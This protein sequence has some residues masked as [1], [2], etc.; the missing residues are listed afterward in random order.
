MWHASEKS[1]FILTGNLKKLFLEGVYETLELFFS[2]RMS[3]EELS[4]ND[5][6]ITTNGSSHHDC[7]NRLSDLE[8][9][10]A[11]AQVTK[12]LTGPA[13]APK[14]LQWNES[15]VYA[16]F[17]SIQAAISFEI[18]SQ[19]DLDEYSHR[20]RKLVSAAERE[21]ID[22]GIEEVEGEES[23]YIDPLSDDH[24]EWDRVVESLADVILWD[25]DFL[26]EDIFLDSPPNRARKVKQSAGI[27]DDY[28][29][30]P[31]P[32]VNKL[33][34]EKAARFLRKAIK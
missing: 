11:V 28:F 30:T 33:R 16:V 7:Y 4:R 15:A 32:A 8:K 27:D 22:Y 14:L 20:W 19:D 31:I 5:D 25:R 23:E 12:D 34:F 17:Q 2:E 29:S 6:F 26:D 21:Q 1:D 13:K 10:Y 9:V 18:D 3:F 24:D